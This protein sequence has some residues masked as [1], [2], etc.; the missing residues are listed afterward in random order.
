MTNKTIDEKHISRI[1]RYRKKL[2]T[3]DAGDFTQIGD[4]SLY[5]IDYEGDEVTINLN[6][7]RVVFD[8]KNIKALMFFQ[9]FYP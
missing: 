4:D 5:V 2:R 8:R 1:N 3:F 6:S 9:E 7:Y